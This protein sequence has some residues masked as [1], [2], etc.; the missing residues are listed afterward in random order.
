MAP[1]W[2]HDGRLIVFR[3]GRHAQAD[4]WIVDANGQTPRRLALGTAPW[5]P[6]FSP[7]DRPSPATFSSND[8]AVFWIGNTAEGDDCLM[9]VKL[10]CSGDIDGDPDVIL[11]FPGKSVNGVSLARDATAVL[12]LN[13]GSTNLFAVDVDAGVAITPPVRLTSDHV[14]YP[15]WSPSG[16]RIVFERSERKASLWTVRLPF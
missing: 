10:S 8:R 2:S 5:T 12:S 3:V 1:T 14:I 7:D 6:R 15:V 9:R 11:S 4:L 16:N 13:E